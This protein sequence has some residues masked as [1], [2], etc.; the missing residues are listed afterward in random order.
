MVWVL[1]YTSCNYVALFSSKEA[2]EAQ[3]EINRDKFG[4]LAVHY[5]II[6]EMEVLGE[7]VP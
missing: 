7:A 3:A 5:P 2:S 6:R 4:G 1:S